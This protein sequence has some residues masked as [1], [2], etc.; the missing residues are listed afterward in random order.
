M[1]ICTSCYLDMSARYLGYITDEE[2][3]TYET[4]QQ[5]RTLQ[6]RIFIFGAQNEVHCSSDLFMNCLINAFHT[7]EDENDNAVESHI[8]PTR[9]H[10]VRSSE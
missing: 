6:N 4:R 5:S 1:H 3:V 8:K 7:F 9:V 2:H 10:P